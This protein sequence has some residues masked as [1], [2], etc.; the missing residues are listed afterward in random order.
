MASWWQKR[1]WRC[2]RCRTELVPFIADLT[3]VRNGTNSAL[4]SSRS[5]TT[6]AWCFNRQNVA[7]LN[8]SLDKPWQVF[9]PAVR[10]AKR[11]SPSRARLPADQAKRR[12][13]PAALGEDRECQRAEKFDPADDAVATAELTH[14]ARAAANREFAQPDRIAGFEHFRV[15]QPRVGHVRMDGV[16]PIG[17]RGRATTATD[18]FVVAEGSVT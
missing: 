17:V 1:S 10:V 14:A 2:R 9:S 5:P 8:R 4:R 15:S 16:C 18:G 11:V 12:I 6:A 7:R 13:R 3:M